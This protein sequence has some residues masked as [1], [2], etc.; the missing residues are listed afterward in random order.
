MQAKKCRQPAV[1]IQ[2][3]PKFDY[4][5]IRPAEH[6]INAIHKGINSIQEPGLP[7]VKVWITGE[8]GLEDDELSGMSNGTF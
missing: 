2:L 5:Q 8:V 4:N 6:A 3:R 1:F 7:K